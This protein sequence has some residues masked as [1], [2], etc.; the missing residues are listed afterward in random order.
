MQEF[1]I[2]SPAQAFVTVVLLGCAACGE[3]PSRPSSAPSVPMAPPV[4]T[5]GS[6]ERTSQTNTGL[7]PNQITGT[8]GPLRPG[9]T[10]C[11]ADRYPCSVHEFTL[12]QPGPIEVSLTW[13][14]APRA[15]MLQLYWAGEG[16]A[17]EDVAPREGPP[18]IAFIRPRMEAT[19]YQVRVVSMEPGNTI[20]FTLSLGY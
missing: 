5:T 3:R 18:R 7:T 6:V 16:L 19:K 20:P 4:L 9:E 10:P 15:L 8:V 2:V 17:H 14:G 1:L 13:D 12:T 11:F